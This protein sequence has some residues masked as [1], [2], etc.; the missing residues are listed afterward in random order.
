MKRIFIFLL[1]C[2]SIICCDTKVK[3]TEGKLIDL[4]PF[5]INVPNDFEYKKLIGIDSFVG[6]ITNGESTFTFDYGMY[7]PRP[8]LTE[9]QFL[10]K[11]SKQLD[12]DA[13]HILMRVIDIKPY[14][15]EQ[16]KVNLRDISKRVKNLKLNKTTEDTKLSM[17][18]DKYCKYYYSLEFDDKHYNIPFFA[19]ENKLDDFNNYAIK[20]DTINDYE[21]TIYFWEKEDTVKYCGIN[22]VPLSNN[23]VDDYLWLGIPSNHKLSK[24]LVIDILNS[25][26][27]KNKNQKSSK[28]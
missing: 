19:Y 20:I 11:N 25:I 28:F 22:M 5:T 27:M 8:P 9:Q 23:P 6:A 24:E 4:G 2:S 17:Y 13:L 16:G 18:A 12:F 1:L 15:N 26:T 10:K 21:R 7:S 14:E 3:Q